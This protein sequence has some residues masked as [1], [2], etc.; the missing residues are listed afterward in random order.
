[1]MQFIVTLKDF[2]AVTMKI[3]DYILACDTL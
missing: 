3:I 2:L 1:M